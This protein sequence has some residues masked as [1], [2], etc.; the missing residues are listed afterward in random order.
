MKVFVATSYSSQVNYETGEVYPEYR[1]YLERQFSVIES[2]GGEVFSAVRHDGYRINDTSPAEAFRVDLD[3]IKKCDVFIAFL[4]SKI[5]AGVQTEIGIAL[6][7]GKK[8][9]L[10]R[11]ADVKSEY[12]NDALIHAG[13]AEGIAL[14]LDVNELNGKI[15]EP[16]HKF[17]LPGGK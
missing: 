8:I 13:V 15:N 7:M 11:P 10:A 5:S 4:N 12:F 1:E 9:L 3:E 14:P 2:A 6:T 16:I 17:S